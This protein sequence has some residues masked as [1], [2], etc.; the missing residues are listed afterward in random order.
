MILLTTSRSLFYL[1]V[2]I[3]IF[4]SIP[5]V[6]SKPVGASHDLK[7]NCFG[8]CTNMFIK[9]SEDVY[10]SGNI[11]SKCL[12]YYPFGECV[13]K[14]YDHHDTTITLQF[15]KEC[16]KAVH[17]QYGKVLKHKKC[18]QKKFGKVRDQCNLECAKEAVEHEDNDEIIT[19]KIKINKKWYSSSESLCSSQVCRLKC[20]DKMIEKQ[21]PQTSKG[22]LNALLAPLNGFKSLMKK[23][24]NHQYF[25]D[26]IVSSKCKGLFEK[27]IVINVSKPS[28]HDDHELDDFKYEVSNFVPDIKPTPPEPLKFVDQLSHNSDEMPISNFSEN[29]IVVVDEEEEEEDVTDDYEEFDNG[30]DSDNQV[31]GEITGHNMDYGDNEKHHEN[32]NVV[33]QAHFDFTQPIQT[34]N[35]EPSN[36]HF[37]GRTPED[38]GDTMV[39]DDEKK[40]PRCLNP[41]LYFVTTDDNTVKEI[42]MNEGMKEKY[43]DGQVSV[44]DIYDQYKDLLNRMKLDDSQISSLFENQPKNNLHNE[45]E[46]YSDIKSE[47][48]GMELLP[49]SNL[50]N[51]GESTTTVHDNEEEYSDNR[52]EF[53]QPPDEDDGSD[54]HAFAK[55]V[56][57][58]GSNS[59][60]NEQLIEEHVGEEKESSLEEEFEEDEILNV[61]QDKD[62]FLNDEDLKSVSHHEPIGFGFKSLEHESKKVSHQKESN[63]QLLKSKDKKIHVERK[64]VDDEF[65]DVMDDNEEDSDM[66]EEDDVEKMEK[67][68]HSTFHGQEHDSNDRFN[69]VLPDQERI[70]YGL[71]GR[72]VPRSIRTYRMRLPVITHIREND[73]NNS[74]EKETSLLITENDKYEN[75]KETKS[76]SKDIKSI[77]NNIPSKNIIY[78]ATTKK[79]KG[80]TNV[81]KKF[82][83]LTKSKS[84]STQLTIEGKPLTLSVSQMKMYKEKDPT[85]DKLK[86][87]RTQKSE[88]IVK[89]KNNEEE[90]TLNNVDTLD[91]DDSGV[92]KADKEKAKASISTDVITVF[93]E[94]Y[95]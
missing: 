21:C 19:N 6:S 82:M 31:G 80:I 76:T 37:I 52:D 55:G 45:N 83:N 67:K 70:S 50:I 15:L 40:I 62:M 41:T 4:E 71:S 89:G 12:P 9:L 46:D 86:L 38:C 53:H 51:N 34:F 1:F 35:I 8:K 72:L 58:H 43:S 7:E 32:S 60:N 87:N 11:S 14:C 56:I 54:F 30:V 66:H 44:V 17:V 61:N 25:K 3:G 48:D 95:K 5:Q 88:K 81:A 39:V 92:T 74:N 78:N 79:D 85:P 47:D 68:S 69:N 57:S 27:N 63:P 65:E 93:P 24:S 29:K 23:S 26:F 77:N 16:D 84:D 36:Y 2:F 13:E 64:K 22:V 90:D 73:D 33:Y 10:N 28:V 49:I 42:F 91:E 20:L 94:L 59:I 18:L 75:L